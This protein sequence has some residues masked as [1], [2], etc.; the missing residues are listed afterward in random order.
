[1]EA[2]AATDAATTC[3]VAFFDVDGT[4]VWRDFKQMEKQ[5]TADVNSAEQIKP[6][7]A[8]YDAFRRM[9]ERGNLTFIC[10]GRSLPF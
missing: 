1:M 3:A 6:T 10:T 9:R 4:L 5:K 7:P 8:V 2:T